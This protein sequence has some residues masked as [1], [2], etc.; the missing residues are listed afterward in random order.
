MAGE[1]EDNVVVPE[2]QKTEVNVNPSPAPKPEPTDKPVVPPTAEEQAAIDA[3][4]AEAKA[5]EEAAKTETEDEVPEWD[6]EYHSFDDP[7]AQSVVDLLNGAGVT[8]T[9]ADSYFSK[10]LKSGNFDDINW[11]AIEAKLGPAQTNLA[12]I[13]VKD[14]HDRV[15][16]VQ[17][18]TNAD[19]Y[20][21]VNGEENWKKVAA[22]V[23]KAEKADPKRKAEFNE[24][25][26]GIDLGGRFAKQAVK[27]LRSLYEADP[28]NSSLGNSKV[29]EG[30]KRNTETVEGIT[31]AEY[32]AELQK[33]GDNIKPAV[34][35]DLQ[36]RR[37]AGRLA[38]I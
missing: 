1:A 33:Y 15:Y 28:N 16:S 17:R 23:S 14:Y 13:G 21:I 10:A 3:K 37:K 27:D 36:A 2:V 19:A 20:E 29:Q 32:V 12:K 38:G 6:G 9:E 35:A 11:K 26:K 4:A 18:Q 5:A 24:L 8:G 22:W 34:Y 31:R 7:A 25:R 30:G